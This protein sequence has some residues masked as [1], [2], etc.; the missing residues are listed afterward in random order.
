MGHNSPKC[1]SC[2]L[3]R[4]SDVVGAA[5]KI[6]RHVLDP[7]NN[8]AWEIVELIFGFQINQSNHDGP[9]TIGKAVR[10]ESVAG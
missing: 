3:K 10:L 2:L 4:A 9:F 1:L 5:V 6:C 8:T 7:W